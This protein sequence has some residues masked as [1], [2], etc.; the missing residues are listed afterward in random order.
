MLLL[1][2]IEA[3]PSCACDSIIEGLFKAMAEPAP[4]R[5]AS[6]WDPRPNL[7]LRWHVEDWTAR[8][9]AIAQKIRDALDTFPTGRGT[10]RA[11]Q[12]LPAV[13]LDLPRAGSYACGSFNKT[14][15]IH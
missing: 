15:F 13:R 5:G 12:G 11:S 14:N 8:M 4:G 9:Q 6:I 10:F 2:N 1:V 3:V 7:F